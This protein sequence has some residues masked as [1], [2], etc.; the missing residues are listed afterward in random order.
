MLFTINA[1]T[2]ARVKSIPRVMEMTDSDLS[3]C[4]K[5]SQQEVVELRGAA[6]RAILQSKSRL[7]TAADLLQAKGKEGSC[8][9]W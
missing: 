6:S 1:D 4:A 2:A 3:R 8:G 5:L 9:R 7:S